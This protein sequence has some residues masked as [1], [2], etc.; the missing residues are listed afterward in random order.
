VGLERGSLS[1]V[2]T[3][4]E[5]LG[6]TS[7]GSGLENWE[8]GRMYP[9][10]WPRG[11]LYLQKLALTSP[12]SGSRFI[13]IVRSRTKA[14]EFFYS[15]LLPHIWAL[16]RKWFSNLGGRVFDRAIART[17]S[18]LVRAQVRSCGICCCGQCD[19]GAGILG[20]LRFL[21]P[22]LIHR[23]LHTHN[24]VSSGARGRCQ[25]MALN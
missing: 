15:L 1:L 18:C 22:I 5:L 25:I 13:G 20:V 7:I 14:T 9:P 3:I 16:V 11:T 12:T 2:S 17:V 10:R 23:L 21:L 4:Q 6:R 8:F 24:H 19:A